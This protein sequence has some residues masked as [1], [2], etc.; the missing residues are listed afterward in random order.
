MSRQEGFD[1]LL[2]RYSR[3]F[4]AAIRRVCR[5][6][7]EQLIP[8]V[9][10]EIRL[11]LWKRLQNED[12]IR[13]PSSY[14]YKMALTTA[15]LVVRRQKQETDLPD[16]EAH[17]AHEPRA[18]PGL[19]PAEARR[20]ID[21]ITQTLSLEQRQA[22]A[23]YAAGFNHQE[24][25]RLYGWTPSTARHRIYRGLDTLREHSPRKARLNHRPL[26]DVSTG[27]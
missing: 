9:E 1:R 20:L 17:P 24:V 22:V 11:A 14:L 4:G 16:P 10:Q 27:T 8:D 18:V 23:A 26:R 6:R 15:A 5:G 21:E 3:V 2:D 7:Y 13:N 19:M 12:E 25:A